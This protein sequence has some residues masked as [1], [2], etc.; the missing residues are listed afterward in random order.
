[1]DAGPRDGGRTAAA[2][3]LGWPS[4]KVRPKRKPLSRI[5]DC[6]HCRP[7]GLLELGDFQSHEAVVVGAG[8]HEGFRLLDDAIITVQALRDTSGRPRPG[9]LMAPCTS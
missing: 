8:W 6:P 2:R 7:H 9:K 1:M 5:V 4:V 3:T